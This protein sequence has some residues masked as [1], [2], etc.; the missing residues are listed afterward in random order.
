VS[1]RQQDLSHKKKKQQTAPSP[2]GSVPT[3]TS[4][5]THTRTTPSEHV[6]LWLL[7]RFNRLRLRYSLDDAWYPVR[8][9]PPLL[10]TE[11]TRG[12]PISYRMYGLDK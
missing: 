1:G 4:R 5:H 11:M 10:Y 9:G 2:R 7:Q 8:N 12:R 3:A 6:L